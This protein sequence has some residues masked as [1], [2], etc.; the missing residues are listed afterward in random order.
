MA[1]AL[2]F[3]RKI[4]WIALDILFTP[5]KRYGIVLIHSQSCLVAA[6]KKLRKTPTK[7]HHTRSDTFFV[8]SNSREDK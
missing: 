4:A 7:F 3:H 2:V 1:F 5:Q 6:D 8:G